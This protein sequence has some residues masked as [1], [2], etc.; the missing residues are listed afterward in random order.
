[1]ESI[2]ASAA[3]RIP[4]APC[5]CVVA[6]SPNRCASSTAARVSSTEYCETSGPAPS[7]TTPPVE[8]ILMTDA[9][10]ATCSRAALRISSTPSATRPISRPCPPVLVSPRPAATMRGPSTMPPSI[11]RASSMTI[12]PFAPRSRTVVTPA[13]SSAR[14]FLKAF[15]VPRAGSWR[16]SLA[17]SAD[18]SN[19]R[20]AWQLMSPG[21]RNRPPVSSVRDRSPFGVFGARERLPTH[22]IVP[23]SIT[24]AASDIV[25]VPSKRPSTSRTVRIATQYRP[26]MPDA[27]TQ[28][29]RARGLVPPDYD[30]RGLLNV[31]ATALDMLG[32]RQPSDPPVLS[33]LDPALRD[34]VRRVATVLIDGLGWG[35]LHALCDDG[36]TPFLAELRDRAR[37]RNSAQLLEA[38]TVF[39]STTA[40]AITTMNTA[41]TPLEHG[42]IAYFAWVEEFAQVTQ[43][44]R[45]GAA[46]TRRGSYFDDA[47]VDPRRYVH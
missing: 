40:A 44:L 24:T 2:P 16:D 45:W 1:M 17:K 27:L 39:P 15:S 37:A 35:Q 31:P 5:A 30:G 28:R 25:R 14:A 23:S 4:A 11:A 20:C 42:N 8:K 19:V 34:G 18:P 13:R 12:V 36:V 7:P 10:A 29:L 3:T 46:I 32:A 41:R 26:R 22:V 47:T 9:P 33:D 38:T 21:G 6:R 43:M